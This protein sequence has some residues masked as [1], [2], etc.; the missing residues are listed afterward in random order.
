MDWGAKELGK[1][2]SRGSIRVIIWIA[3][4]PYILMND[5]AFFQAHKLTRFGESDSKK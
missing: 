2:A 5:S 3:G 4:M 1:M